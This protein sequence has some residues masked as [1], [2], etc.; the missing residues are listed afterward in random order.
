MKPRRGSKKLIISKSRLTN[1]NR[2]DY[3]TN[4][5]NGQT[6]DTGRLLLATKINTTG[7]LS[8]DKNNIHEPCIGERSEETFE[9]AGSSLGIAALKTGRFAVLFEKMRANVQKIV[10]SLGAVELHFPSA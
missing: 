7:L 1:S 8:V 4:A 9:E 10:I 2:C 6:A 3:K 5:V